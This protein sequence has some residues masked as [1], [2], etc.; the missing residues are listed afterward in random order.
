MAVDASASSWRSLLADLLEAAHASSP[1]PPTTPSPAPDGFWAQLATT[2]AGGQRDRRLEGRPA[3]RTV[4]L[5]GLRGGAA[6]RDPSVADDVILYFITDARSDKA[7]DAAASPGAEL[8]LFFPHSMCQMR[9]S[10]ALRMEGS[11]DLVASVWASLSAKE[12]RYFVWPPPGQPR[13]AA[14]GSDSDKDTFTAY[15]PGAAPAE[16]PACFRLGVLDIDY[17]EYLNLGAFPPVRTQFLSNAA[18]GWYATEV[19]P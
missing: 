10:G 17:A 5:R 7:A 1:P 3:V 14:V 13:A 16:R 18:G 12:R 11:T 15:A 9:L 19:N 2:R 8:L 6:A 4:N